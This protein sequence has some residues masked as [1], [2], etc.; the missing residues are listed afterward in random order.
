ATPRRHPGPGVPDPAAGRHAVGERRR[1]G[2]RRRRRGRPAY[3]RAPD[4]PAA[5]QHRRG[6]DRP[7]QGG[8]GR[9][10]GPSRHRPGQRQPP[11]APRG[12][13]PPRPRQLRHE[14]WRGGGAPPRCDLGHHRSRRHL[15]LLRVRGGGGRAQRADQA[16]RKPPRAPRGR[17]RG[18]HGAVGR[19]RGGRLPGN[20]AGPCHR[21]RR[22][23]ALGAVVDGQ[24][25]DPCRGGGVG[26]APALRAASRCGR[27]VGVPGRTQ[28]RGRRGRGSRERRAR[29]VPRH[30]QL[31][32]RARPVRDGSGGVRPGALRAVPRRGRGLGAGSPAGARR[33]RG[34]RLRRRGRRHPEAEV[35]VDRR[36]AVQLA[37]RTRGQLWSRRPHVC[38]PAGRTRAGGPDRAGLGADARLVGGGRV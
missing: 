13:G 2:H 21:G 1:A 35:R 4:C 25:R 29:P 3:G 32:V 5:R 36:G 11:L 31:P 30:G 34:G 16:R 33:T 26:P 27:R 20:A 8:T 10:G 18:A 37:R 17:L 22:A 12:R 38:P 19:R 23:R 15:P 6:P 28:R 24:Q 14:G 9:G 7:G